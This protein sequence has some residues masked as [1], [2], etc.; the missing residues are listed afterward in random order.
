M[1]VCECGCVCVRASVSVCEHLLLVARIWG[2]G[3]GVIR[4]RVDKVRLLLF[5][6]LLPLLLQL[7]LS[8]LL[9]VCM[10]AWLSLRL[11]ADPQCRRSLPWCVFDCPRLACSYEQW[12]R[13]SARDQKHA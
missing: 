8:L 9:R 5:L 10:F 3:E 6:L 7:Q 12:R 1:R 2:G 11:L 4:G 13:R